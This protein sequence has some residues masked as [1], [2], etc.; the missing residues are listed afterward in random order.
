MELLCSWLESHRLQW[1]A[2]A[3]AWI[4]LF[5]RPAYDSMMAVLVLVC[6]DLAVGIWAAK[7][8][9]E[10]ITSYGF[11][12][13]ITTKIAPYQ[14]AVLLGYYV[15]KE[16]SLG[17]PLMKAI[18]GFIAVAE[19]KS[20]FENLG[21]ITGLDFWTAIKEKLQPAVKA[22]PKDPPSAPGK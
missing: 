2:T 19:L 1:V 11:R 8:R 15:D 17:I 6:V 20:I 12:R 9:G 5:T 22:T 4:V 18:A 21:Q 7:K 13:S 16:F 10:P 3:L 14:V